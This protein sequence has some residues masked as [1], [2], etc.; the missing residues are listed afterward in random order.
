MNSFYVTLDRFCQQLNIKNQIK[1]FFK[2][3]NELKGFKLF[4]HYFGISIQLKGH[5]SVDKCI[6]DPKKVQIAAKL[7]QR[8]S[9]FFSNFSEP[10]FEKFEKQNLP[11]KSNFFSKKTRSSTDHTY[12]CLVNR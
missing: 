4:L 8:L 1:F 11:K 10:F 2:F 3:S 6:I 9:N 12:K 5:F 7:Y